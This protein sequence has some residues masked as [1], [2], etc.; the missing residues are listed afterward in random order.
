MQLMVTLC[1]WEFIIHFKNSTSYFTAFYLYLE[2]F[3]KIEGRTQLVS[4]QEL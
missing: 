4:N 1:T 3:V 2:V